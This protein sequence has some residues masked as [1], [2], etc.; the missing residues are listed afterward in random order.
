MSLPLVVTASKGQREC[1]T[2]PLVRATG[3]APVPMANRGAGLFGLRG[4]A[5]DGFY[6]P[7]QDAMA[8]RTAIELV[9]N[10]A[11]LAE[12]VGRNARE[13]VLGGLTLDHYVQRLSA[14][15]VDD[16]DAR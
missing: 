3:P 4:H 10:D 12:A 2:G 13:T 9:A 16:G 7:P 15:L 11:S 1:V 14:L 5:P 6:V 8:L